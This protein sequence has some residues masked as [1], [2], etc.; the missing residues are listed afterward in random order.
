MA[1]KV[2][3]LNPEVPNLACVMGLAAESTSP[4]ITGAFQQIYGMSAE[5]VFGDNGDGQ[6]SPAE[7]ARVIGIIGLTSLEKGAQ[8]TG[9]SVREPSASLV[10]DVKRAFPELD[11]QYAR[12]LAAM[13]GVPIE[14]IR[15][16][17]ARL[18]DRVITGNMQAAEDAAIARLHEILDGAK[19][20]LNRGNVSE[21]F[22]DAGLAPPEG[23]VNAIIEAAKRDLDAAPSQVPPSG[24]G[25]D[26]AGK[27]PGVLVS[28]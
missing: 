20:I 14:T 6:L 23:D 3:A 21:A 11:P 4:F 18:D 25:L 26:L 7:A 22:A 9:F 5:E 27:C 2:D 15:Q 16:N 8:A 13:H 28:R 24:L 19:G 1:D 12:G 10:S 17:M